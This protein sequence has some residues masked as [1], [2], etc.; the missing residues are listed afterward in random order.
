MTPCSAALIVDLERPVSEAFSRLN[1]PGVRVGIDLVVVADVA[2]S[3]ERLGQRYLQR[4][5]TPHELSC[6]RVRPA[7]DG[8]YGYSAEALAARFAAKEATVKVLRPVGTRPEW[9][10]IEVR[11]AG[12]GWCEIVGKRCL[13][14][15]RSRHR[16]VGGQP[17]A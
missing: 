16:R 11:R 10:S 14:G 1:G 4:V 17:H 9:R 13:V 15:C 6:C 12:G 2:E 8:Q 3:L 7:S 5:F